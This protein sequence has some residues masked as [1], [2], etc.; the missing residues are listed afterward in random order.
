MQ[1]FLACLNIPLLD[2]KR[3]TLTIIYKSPG[4][5]RQPGAHR[6][7]KIQKAQLRVRDLRR[8]RQ[9]PRAASRDHSAAEETRECARDGRA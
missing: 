2:L 3:I 8:L 6:V 5:P 7:Q 9:Q 1:D 4:K